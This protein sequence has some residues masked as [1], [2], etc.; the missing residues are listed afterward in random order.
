MVNLRGKK[1]KHKSFGLGTV[2]DQDA[3]H[4]TV[5]FPEKTCKFVYPIAFEK[6]LE[7]DDPVLRNSISAE[8]AAKIAAEEAVKAAEVA[9]QEAEKQAKLKVVKPQ[10]VKSN[11]TKI[12]APRVYKT[13]KPVKRTPG[14]IK[15]Y[16]VFQ[17][18]TFEEEYLGRFLWAPKYTKSG[19]T[20]HHWERMVEICQ[21]DVIFHCSNGYV[22]AISKAQGAYVDSPRPT[23]NL[24][25]VDWTQWENNGRK[26]SCDYHLLRKPLK[27]GDYKKIIREYCQEK[28][29]PFDKDGDGNMGYLFDLNLELARIF[30]KEIAKD[31]PE[32]L[33]LEYLKP[34]LQ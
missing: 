11:G 6:F 10:P 23:V 3:G 22:R 30:I 14:K 34:L 26:V 32:V 16:L 17:G 12:T 9:R 21:G 2:I 1:V 15:T 19:G 33:K 5:E 20:R 25:G 18:D 29:A 4:V 28:Y 31:N 8:I 7:L 27:H 13:Y 24:T